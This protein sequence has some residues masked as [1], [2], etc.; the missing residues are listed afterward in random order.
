MPPNMMQLRNT[1]HCEA[2][3]D[4]VADDFNSRQWF[5]LPFRRKRDSTCLNTVGSIFCY[6]LT[7]VC[8]SFCTE[9]PTTIA[10][11]FP[12]MSPTH[13]L[14]YGW[15]PSPKEAPTGMQIATFTSLHE[16]RFMRQNE[17]AILQHSSYA[18][19]L[20]WL[21]AHKNLH[22]SLK[23]CPSTY[24]RCPRCPC[25]KPPYRLYSKIKSTVPG[26]FELGVKVCING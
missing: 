14:E 15:H 2:I 16:S 17:S 18:S 11:R 19:A 10:L 20:G 26:S 24:R 21:L 22:P 13:W 6:K 25:T 4:H 12:R 1:L 7:S 23:I 9:I 3:E 8:T 5:L